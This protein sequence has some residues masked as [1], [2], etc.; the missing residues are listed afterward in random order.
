M[1]TAREERNHILQLVE[2]GKVTA[3]QAAQLL[4]MLELERKG[5]DERLKGRSVRVRVTKLATSQQKVNVVLP[6]H[7]LHVGLRLATR[8]APQVSGSALED[9]LLAMAGGATGRLLD[10]QDLEEDERVEIFAEEHR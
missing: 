7:L 3:A 2:M 10:L 4:D 6:V 5:S 8:L 9:L 1:A